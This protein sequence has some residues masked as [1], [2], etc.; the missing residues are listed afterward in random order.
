MKS[1][2]TK[3]LNSKITNSI[4]E[5]SQML[6]FI[7][8]FAALVVKLFYFV[9]DILATYQP[10]ML[11]E[12]G[13]NYYLNFIYS[14]LFLLFI[15]VLLVPKV[16]VN[17]ALNIFILSAMILVSLMLSVT[18]VMEISNGLAIPAAAVNIIFNCFL[19]FE[20]ALLSGII[21][22]KHT[23]KL[24][25]LFVLLSYLP[26]LIYYA[27]LTYFPDIQHLYGAW[28]DASGRILVY[29][30]IPSIKLFFSPQLFLMAAF[31]LHP[32]LTSPLKNSARKYSSF[33]TIKLLIKS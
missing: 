11:L 9:P 13:L 10:K 19:S 27:L 15:I 21:F 30:L 3:L 24:A 1:I 4:R 23:E 33:Q 2:K 28:G 26:A 14:L 8:A 18:S 22:N 29:S 5:H 32:V 16:R 31:V 25:A 17:K 6:A 20:T 7:A 12:N